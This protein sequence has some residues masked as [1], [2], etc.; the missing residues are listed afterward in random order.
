M[1][2]ERCGRARQALTAVVA[3]VLVAFYQWTPY[4]PLIVL[5]SLFCV[6]L[7]LLLL[8]C[9]EVKRWSKRKVTGFFVCLF[10]ERLFLPLF[11]SIQQK[12][13]NYTIVNSVNS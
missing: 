10:A 13:K 9:G 6:F 7:L 12:K 2:G 4:V 1:C 3:V 11:L 5:K 8:L